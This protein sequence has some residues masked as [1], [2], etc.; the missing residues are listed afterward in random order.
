MTGNKEF[1]ESGKVIG[2]VVA[3]CVGTEKGKGKNQQEF[4][5][6]KSGCGV[7][8]DAH[9]GTEK[10]VSIL[11]HHLVDDFVRETGLDAPAG[12]FAENIRIRWLEPVELKIGSFLAVGNAMVEI[13][14]LGKSPREKHRFSYKGHGLL[15]N[16][17]IFAKVIRDGEVK[18][19]DPVRM[20]ERNK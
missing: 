11:S 17:G 13:T 7:L 9:A 20:A 1:G 4:I 14:G 8:G 12:C 10:E 16:W 18:S 15:V 2:E 3:V 5:S 6:L 19:G